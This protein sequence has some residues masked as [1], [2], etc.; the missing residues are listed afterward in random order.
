MK[1]IFLL[2]YFG[3]YPYWLDQWVANM[4]HLDYDYKIFSN[5]KLFENRIREILDI[6]PYIIGGTGKPWA[7]RPTLGLLYADEIKG[8][9]CWGHTDFD[10]VYGDVDSYMPKEFDIWSNHY[11]Y[12]CG[13]WTLYKNNDHINNLFRKYPYWKEELESPYAVG[14][15]ESVEGTTIVNENCNVV[16]THYQTKSP[17]D[18]SKVRYENGKLYDGED[19]IMLA[20]FNH[21]K[22]YPIERYVI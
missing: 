5:K 12:I 4:E 16:Y 19:E 7:F 21:T 10:C 6:E 17:D 3:Q 22:I 8:Y 11:N 9:D 2:P 13:H 20:H 18:F 14:W 15:G 1:K